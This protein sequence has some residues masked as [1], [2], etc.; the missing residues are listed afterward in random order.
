MKKVKL[1]AVLAALAAGLCLYLYLRAANT[2][3]QVATTKVV[4]AAADIEANTVVTAEMLTYADIPSAAVLP[5]CVTSAEEA[6][7]RIT[8]SEVL[9]GEQLL[10]RR[11]VDTVGGQTGGSL[12]YSVKE[13]MRAMT[14]AV[15]DTTGLAGMLRPGNRVDVTVLYQP[16]QTADAEA[17]DQPKMTAQILLQNVGVLAVDKVL[18]KAGSEDKYTTVTL[19]LEPGQALK[20]TL[21][22][23]MGSISLL[24]R[25]PTDNDD[26]GT[27]IIDTD[28]LG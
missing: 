21:A 13:G 20:L 26:A 2:P 5:G 24:L 16:Q 7:G 15:T 25:A 11:L 14:I 9:A 12:S 19:E 1:I 3:A 22:Q 17:A 10:A 4:V 8:N 27:G 23:S 28:V 6:V 18:D